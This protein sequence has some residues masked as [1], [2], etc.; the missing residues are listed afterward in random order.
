MSEAL[1]AMVAAMI[2]DMRDQKRRTGAANWIDDEFGPE[3]V[4]VD[5]CLDVV[6]LAKAA[7]AAIRSPTARM[8]DAS[9]RP[10]MSEPP[11][12]QRWM[13]MIDAIVKD[14]P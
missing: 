13:A 14:E 8:I 1:K 12:E 2:E 10:D 11:E 5:G 4:V 7:L 6:R 9:H 3:E